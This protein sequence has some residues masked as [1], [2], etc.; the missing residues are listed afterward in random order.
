[1]AQRSLKGDVKVEFTEASSRQ[2][3][4]SGESVKTLFGKIRKW[5]SD[6]KPVAFSGSYADL[7]DKP[8]VD[9]KVSKTGDTMTGLLRLKNSN[10]DRDGE[11]SSTTTGNAYLTIQDKDNEA[12]STFSAQQTADGTMRCNMHVINE[13][14]NGKAVNNYFQVAIDKDGVPSYGMSNPSAFRSA[15]GLDAL[16]YYGL[17]GRGTNTYT[18]PWALIAETS[19]INSN[20][21]ALTLLFDYGF[22]TIN[23]SKGTG[24]LSVNVR[25]DTAGEATTNSY[26]KWLTKTKELNIDD[27]IVTYN[28]NTGLIQIWGKSDYPYKTIR[29]RPLSGG[30]FSTFDVSMWTFTTA[31]NTNLF[32]SYP[33]GDGIT[34]LTPT[35]DIQ[36]QIECIDINA[37]YAPATGEVHITNTSDF[38]QQLFSKLYVYDE[39]RF[40]VL[41]LSV[42]SGTYH[43]KAIINTAAITQATALEATFINDDTLYRFYWTSNG[44]PTLTRRTLSFV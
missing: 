43:I 25:I 32:E 33:T 39:V 37:A 40:A 19:A 9:S 22:S 31:L 14:E 29:V 27:V 17:A 6:L 1:M 11:V 18:N 15:I 34:V 44:T 38:T 2:G 36:E 42:T 10:I 26:V 35:Y 4:D 21:M 20:N 30:R 41:N 28:N 7:T 8:A 3:I 23:T 16:G 24:I 5:L 12:V 13:K